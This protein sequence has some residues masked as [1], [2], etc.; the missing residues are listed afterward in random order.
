MDLLRRQT[1]GDTLRR[2]ARRSP[3]RLALRFEDQTWTYAKLDSDVNRVAHGLAGIGIVKGD[4][5]AVLSR[6]SAYFVLL[7]FALAKIGA[8]LVPI[9]FMLR[10]EEVAH[11][12]RHSGA[13]FLCAAP[14]LAGTAA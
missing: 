2:S 12:L 3:E 1:L 8:V 10:A 9:N 6:N 14:D 4:R 11:V 5:V 13:R 7:R